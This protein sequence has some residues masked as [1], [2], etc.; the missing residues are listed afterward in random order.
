MRCW[1]GSRGYYNLNEDPFELVN[2][3]HDGRFRTERGALQDRLR[4]WMEGTGDAF[5]LPEIWR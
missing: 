1:R 2:L 4:E 5:A 3:A